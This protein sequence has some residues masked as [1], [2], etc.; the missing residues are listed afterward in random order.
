M[1]MQTAIAAGIAALV[2]TGGAARA[3]QEL[4][5]GVTM[6]QKNAIVEAGNRFALELYA[7]LRAREGNL[8]LSPYSI[9]TALTMTYAGARG[10]TAAQMARVLH[11]PA[12]EAQLHRAVAALKDE[13]EGA[14]AAEGC[15]LS[16][17]NALWGQKGFDF[18]AGFL[19]LLQ[20][21][22]GARLTEL[23][24]AGNA[25]G[26]R[27]TINDWVEEQ[28]SG[29]IKDIIAPG[30][31][32]PLTR[33]VLTNAIYF[34]GDWTEPF[35]EER[36]RDEPFWTSAEDS[37]DAP[38]MHQTKDFQYGES[39][40]CQALLLPYAKGRLAMLVLLPKER[41]GLAKL[42]G[43]L[44]VE[45][46]RQWLARLR[47]REVEL[48]LPRFKLTSQFAL[49]DPLREMGMGD[50]FA[51]PPADFSGMDGRKD[52]F[53]SAVIHKAFVD[54]NEEGTEAAAAT[55]VTMV[56]G[57]AVAPEPPVVFRAD[58]PFLFFIVERRSGS[59]LFMG[60]LSDP[61]E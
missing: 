14:G 3:V 52:L 17:A 24:F 2:L 10:E 31:L 8:F 39:G 36:T 15:E 11:L 46:V 19:G 23:D 40:E 60:R 26:A 44:K 18:L 43:G 33:L 53:I 27:R 16:I 5:P 41:D 20:D 54:V 9:A 37:A 50:A 45:G 61:A 6:Q 48:S 42:E 51:L 32:G 59:I 55:A 29:K 34:K 38:M 35:K 58:H 21:S 1:R 57:A 22:Y 25:E 13:I 12:E 30:V 7:Q 49:G 56:L 28:T 47:K 4:A